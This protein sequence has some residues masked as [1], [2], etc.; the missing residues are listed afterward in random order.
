MPDFNSE[1]NSILIKVLRHYQSNVSQCLGC[2]VFWLSNYKLKSGDYLSQMDHNIL[3]SC[4]A[5]LNDQLPSVKQLAS[6]KI[7]ISHSLCRP[8]IREKMIDYYRRGQ[9][10]SGY[11]PCYATA[12]DGHC[13]QPHCAYYDFCVVDQNELYNWEER[14]RRFLSAEGCRP[15]F[16]ILELDSSESSIP[17]T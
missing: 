14:K 7:F 11:H 10:Q 2:G 5:R 17:Q 1:N 9:K 8:C 3:A 16:S 15:G 6:W 4:I 13:S 12:V